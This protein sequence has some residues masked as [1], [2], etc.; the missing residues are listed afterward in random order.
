MS[1][2]EQ[3]GINIP[4]ILIPDTEKTDISKWSVIACDQFTASTDYWDD[5]KIKTEG[6]CSTVNL[7]LPECYLKQVDIDKELVKINSNMEKYLES[8][9]LKNL[10]KVLF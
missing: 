2:F 6:S 4:E 9:V 10:K 3:M 8:G 1:T 7:I 5:V